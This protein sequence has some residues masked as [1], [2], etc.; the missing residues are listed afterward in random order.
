MMDGIGL[1]WLL[2]HEPTYAPTSRLMSNEAIAA[3]KVGDSRT[4]DLSPKLANN[5]SFQ[6]GA[7]MRP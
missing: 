1:Q 6:M 7:Q 4:R 2:N 3:W 5:Q